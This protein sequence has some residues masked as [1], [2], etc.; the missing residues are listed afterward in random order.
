MRRA[1]HLE[2][3]ERL[4]RGSTLWIAG[5]GRSLSPLLRSGDGLKVLRCAP[6]EVRPGDLAVV[7]R[8]GGLTAHLVD[9]VSPLS[10]SSLLGRRDPAGGQLLGRV[11]AVRARGVVLPLTPGSR[12][13]LRVLHRG[14]AAAWSV[15][16]VRSAVRGLWELATSAGTASLRGRRLGPVAVERLTPAALEP[17]LIFAGDHLALSADF[18]ERQLPGRWQVEGAAVG[19]FDARRRLV[20]FAFLDDDRPEGVA[21]DGGWIRSVVVAPKARSLGIEGQLVAQLCEHARALGLPSVFAELPA[22]DRRS[23]RLFTGLGFV[24][25]G[26]ALPG[27]PRLILERRI[28]PD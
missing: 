23:Q 16:P 13:L 1:E 26:V 14:L 2:L 19:A 4:P 25:A 28:A 11:I 20:G 17:L 21:L 7:R 22:D 9:S 8:D 6:D 3:L 5:L 24:L 27:P 12:P 18:L 15:A 10:T